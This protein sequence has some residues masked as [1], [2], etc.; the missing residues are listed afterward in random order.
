MSHSLPLEIGKKNSLVLSIIAAVSILFSVLL[1]MN[2]PLEPGLQGASS[3]SEKC[4]ELALKYGF[5]ESVCLHREISNSAWSDSFEYFAIAVGEESFAPFSLRPLIPKAV[6][7]LSKITLDESEKSNKDSLFKRISLM[8]VF[9]NLIT[10]IFLIVI[11][12]FAYRTLYSENGSIVMLVVLTGVI[13]LGVVQTSP[14]FMLDMAS[15][16]VFM[17]AAYFFFNRNILLL[18]LTACF[19]VFVKEISIILVIP[20]L[21]L[22]AENFKKNPQNVFFVSLPIIVFS[23]LRVLMGEDPLSM[24]YSWKI[25]E[26]MVKTHYLLGHIGGL[27]NILFFVAKVMAGLGGILAMVI[28][29]RRSE[30][31][32]DIFFIATISMLVAVIIANVLL[33]SRVPRVVGVVMPFFLFYTLFILN[34]K[35]E[36]QNGSDRLRKISQK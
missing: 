15:Y 8:A 30:S 25:S 35:V 22:V 32:T 4:Q 24:Q 3:S 12:L 7:S 34:K 20:I 28:Y 21:A 16:L 19:G 2:F 27:K 17:V 18:T 10:G 13:S 6:G 23:A 9:V 31:E 26:G 1:G 36:R 14:F 11:P 5:S 33:A 29:L